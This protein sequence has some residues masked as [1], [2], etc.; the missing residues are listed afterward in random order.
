[1]KP[2]SNDLR[3]KVIKAYEKGEGSLRKTAKRFSV[4]LN[5]VWLLWERYRR[6]GSVAPKPHGGG[7]QPAIAGKDLERLRRLVDRHNDATLAEIRELFNRQAGM[8]VSASTISRTL[9]RLRL[10]R[11]KKTLHASERDQ[12]EEVR[13]SRE[14]FQTKMAQMQANKLVFIDETGTHLG[15]TRSYAWAP[16]GQRALGERPYD[17]GA[18]ISLVGALSLTG[19]IAALMIDGAVDGEVFRGFVQQFLVPVLQS[20]DVVLLDNLPAHKV[21]GVEAAIVSAG[22]TVK[23]LPAYSPDLSPIEN[24]WSKVKE[25]LRGT[26]ARKLH[27][28]IK[29]VKQALES[30]T[31]TDAQ[32]WFEH[33]GYCIEPK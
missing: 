8:A 27:G 18:N 25:A 28:L 4:S 13:K 23:F 15:M 24:A 12:K 32:G 26:A 1:M 17:T 9:K 21:Q 31:A 16:E 2:Y 7:R 30:V 20:G 14:Q 6:T 33:C 10:T 19:V 3:T 22:A 29:G 11:K 5:F